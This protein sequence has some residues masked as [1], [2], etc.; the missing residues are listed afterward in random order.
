[1]LQVASDEGNSLASYIL[2]L[3]HESGKAVPKNIEKAKNYYKQ[4]AKQGNSYGYH[5]LA[6]VYYNWFDTKS[7]KYFQ[8]AVNL[9]NTSAMNYY[10]DI[11]KK[12]TIFY[13]FFVDIF[14]K[15]TLIFQRFI[16]ESRQISKLNLSLIAENFFFWF[17]LIFV[18]YGRSLNSKIIISLW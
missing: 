3:L 8:K 15:S 13:L 7:V 14:I 5:K 2:G 16:S 12:I 11:I 10:N 9:G 6:L 1:M 17:F 4:S 18:Y